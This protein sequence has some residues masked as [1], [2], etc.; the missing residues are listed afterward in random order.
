M[1]VDVDQVVAITFAELSVHRQSER[2]FLKDVKDTTT[3]L[4]EGV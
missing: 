4:V 1:A 2:Q 3:Y